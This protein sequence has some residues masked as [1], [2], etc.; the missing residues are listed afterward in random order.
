MLYRARW[1]WWEMMGWLSLW[2]YHQIPPLKL[3]RKLETLGMNLILFLRYLSTQTNRLN[4]LMYMCTSTYIC[5]VK[6]LKYKRY[7]FLFRGERGGFILIW[8]KYMYKYIDFWS[9]KIVISLI[10]AQISIKEKITNF[11]NLKL[12]TVFRI[13]ICESKLVL[14]NAD[15]VKSYEQSRIHI[16][17]YWW[18]FICIN[19][20][21][22][23]RNI[24]TVFWYW[25]TDYMNLPLAEIK[26]VVKFHFLFE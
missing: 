1:S 13:I 3:C 21:S 17:S 11:K 2:F 10:S 20:K 24:D 9:S 12:F 16:L 19:I 23:N 5:I 18:L 15:F 22:H 25:K 6:F 4:N 14:V 7:R 26:I 8:C